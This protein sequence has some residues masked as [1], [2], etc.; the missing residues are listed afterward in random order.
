MKWRHSVA[1]V[2]AWRLVHDLFD[3]LS[4]ALIVPLGIVQIAAAVWIRRRIDRSVIAWTVFATFVSLA[5][6]IA[7]GV[8]LDLALVRPV[9]LGLNFCPG[10][11]AFVVLARRRLWGPALLVFVPLPALLAILPR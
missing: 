7:A 9:M 8:S 3:R 6:G 2:A 5:T 4:W 11:P 1:A 10:I